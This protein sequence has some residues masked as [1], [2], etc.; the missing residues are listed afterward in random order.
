MKIKITKKT[1]HII[2][3]YLAILVILY[4]VAFQIPGMTTL[5][6]TTQVLENG[7]LEVSCE[8]TGYVVKDEAVCTADTTGEISFTTESGTVVKKG[9]RIA[10]IEESGK[11]DKEMAGKYREYLTRLKNYPLLA[12]GNSAPISGVFSTEIDGYEKYFSIDNL[13]KINKEKTEA[14]SLGKLELDRKS[15]VKGEPIF[16]ISGDDKWYV[17][18]W[19]DKEDAGKYSEGED[20]RL[21]V[22]ED[23]LD[24]K[25]YS[26]NKEGEFVKTVLYL[27]VYYEDFCRARVLDMTIV[28]SNTTGLIVDNECI[29]EKDGQQGV[30]VKTKDGDT[31][32]KPIKVKISNG[33]QSVI[34]DSVFINDEYEQ[35]ETVTVYQEVLR[36][37]EEALEED[38][39][40]EATD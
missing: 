11:K 31:Y 2:A 5:F 20:V 35:V 16:K 39:K 1:R 10:E 19:L 21:A 40:N 6:E 24:G 26:K 7:T 38:M 15:V 23:T 14:L 12:Q 34:Y 32:F 29:I 22:G 3:A 25:V 17:V 30:Y 36:H 33:E 8:A 13:D 27:N 9:T 4:L 18:C 28:Q 37:P